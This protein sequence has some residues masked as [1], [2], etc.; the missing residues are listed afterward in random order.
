MADFDFKSFTS[1]HLPLTLPVHLPSS[2]DSDRFC[3][4]LPTLL[5]CLTFFS[6]ICSLNAYCILESQ[7][8]ATEGYH[9]PVRA[10]RSTLVGFVLSYCKKI[11]REQPNVNCAQDKRN[12]KWYFF[13]VY[14]A[15][16]MKPSGTRKN[17][18]TGYKRI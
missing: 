11:E 4:A 7:L 13:N 1:T 16:E 10:S 18:R 8:D 9:S 3:P 17:L 6:I 2:G 15:R 12:K 5:H 14:L